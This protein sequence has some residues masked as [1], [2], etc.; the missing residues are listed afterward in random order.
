MS[1]RVLPRQLGVVIACDAS[2]LTGFAACSASV[3]T[4]NCLIRT[5][6]KHLPSGWARGKRRGYKRYDFCPT[7]APQEA[8]VAAKVA[9]DEKAARA[10]EVL[11]RRQQRKAETERRR[12]ERKVQRAAE[13]AAARAAKTRAA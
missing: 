7:C 10:A 3:R 11:E 6:R 2:K 8:T 12:A 4:N 1:A 13:R 9:A 5:N